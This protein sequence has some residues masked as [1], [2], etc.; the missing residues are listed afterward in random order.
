MIDG[1][2]LNDKRDPSPS[3]GKKPN[4]QHIRQFTNWVKINIDFFI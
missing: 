2:N 3:R 4:K 1:L